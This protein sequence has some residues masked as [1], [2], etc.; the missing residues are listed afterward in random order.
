MLKQ[1]AP[2]VNWVDKRWCRDGKVWTSG[3]LLNGLDLMR[4][5]ASEVWGGEGTLAEWWLAL[6][7]WPV[8]DVDYK[9]EPPTKTEAAGPTAAVSA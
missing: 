9:D 7:S 2:N 8:R 3:A 4:A 6:G 5:F 1:Q